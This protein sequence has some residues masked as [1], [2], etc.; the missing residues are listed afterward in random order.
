MG[1]HR[2]N[3]EKAEELEELGWDALGFPEP[4]AGGNTQTA[5]EYF[6]KALTYDP[7]LADAYNGLGTAFYLQKRFAE[8]EAMYRTAL[9]KARTQ[10][11]TFAK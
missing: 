8:A 6:R 1:K 4:S 10:L 11:M 9:Q 2:Q 5:E 7:D 3:R